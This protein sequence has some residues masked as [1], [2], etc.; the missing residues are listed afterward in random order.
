M[1]SL[2]CANEYLNFYISN[3]P[4]GVNMVAFNNVITSNTSEINDKSGQIRMLFKMKNSELQQIQKLARSQI[5][6]QLNYYETNQNREL[7]GVGTDSD[8]NER[9][10]K[11]AKKWNASKLNLDQ[12]RLNT[13]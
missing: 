7:N 2:S 12:Y 11:I 13:K 5:I 3:Q 1:R 8:L 4:K 10:W 9:C 6:A